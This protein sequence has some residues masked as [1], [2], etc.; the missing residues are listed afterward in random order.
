MVMLSLYLSGDINNSTEG[1]LAVSNIVT[2]LLSKE[3]T[4]NLIVLRSFQGRPFKERL[5]NRQQKKAAADVAAQPKKWR[6]TL[7]PETTYR[8]PPVVSKLVAPLEVSAEFSM[9]WQ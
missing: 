9:L 7:V 6:A 8:G 4:R 2:A 5:A 3:A 1:P